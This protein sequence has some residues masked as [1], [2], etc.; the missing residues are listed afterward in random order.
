[1]FN[2][3]SVSIIHIYHLKRLYRKLNKHRRSIKKVSKVFLMKKW[4]KQLIY[5]GF[6]GTEQIEIIQGYLD[7][8]YTVK[9]VENM[10]NLQELKI[11]E[12][13]LWEQINEFNKIQYKSI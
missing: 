10:E 4:L 11:K 5:I 9:G 8:K 3:A 7:S 6:R 1:M 2:G 13:E 12:K